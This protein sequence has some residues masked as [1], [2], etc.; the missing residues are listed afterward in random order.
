MNGYLF[1]VFGSLSFEGGRHGG[2]RRERISH[3]IA[4]G[5][6]LSNPPARRLTT[7]QTI[8]T[9]S[10]VELTFPLDMDLNADWARLCLLFPTEEPSVLAAILHRTGQLL[11]AIQNVI[12]TVA[13]NTACLA[14]GQL[15]DEA[16]AWVSSA[17][18][19]IDVDVQLQHWQKHQNLLQLLSDFLPPPPAD[20]ERDPDV[21]VNAHLDLIRLASRIQPS[22]DER[23]PLQPSPAY[24]SIP[25]PANTSKRRRLTELAKGLW[26]KL[27][28]K[29]VPEDVEVC[30]L[31]PAA[32][33]LM[34]WLLE[35][36]E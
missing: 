6:I 13:L 20:W 30:V 24:R 26:S 17:L 12:R 8:S 14:E 1:W 3:Q 28:R 29:P 36:D 35:R 33:R 27:L 4:S 25:T 22:W 15:T 34:T 5:H 19:N 2:R 23:R 7:G 32:F 16:L 31:N 11:L 10:K 9:G 18:P 21:P